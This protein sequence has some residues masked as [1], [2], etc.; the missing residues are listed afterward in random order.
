[1]FKKKTSTDESGN[2]PTYLGGGM[3]IE[4]KV[5]GR[6]PI[7]MDGQLK[8]TI[9]CESEVV[10]GPTAK[11]EA[12]IHASIIKVNGEVKG[13]LFALDR[14][15]VLSEG[16]IRGNITNLPGS[17]I[18][19]EGGVVEGQCLTTSQQ[20]LEKLI[21]RGKVRDEME[22]TPPPSATTIPMA[23]IKAQ[24]EITSVSAEKNK[25]PES[26]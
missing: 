17:L 15:E 26:A 18:I 12:A 3:R 13:D 22:K 21:P 14:M 24:P 16:R 23:P 20:E 19:H 11:I 1:M 4:G 5:T 10:I 7:W 25:P 2:A 8:G 6:R 9:D